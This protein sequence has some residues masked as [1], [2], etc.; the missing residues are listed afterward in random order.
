MSK[1]TFSPQQD[2]SSWETKRLIKYKS[3]LESLPSRQSRSILASISS[4]LNKKISIDIEQRISVLDWYTWL[5]PE[6]KE[7]ISVT[8]EYIQIWNIRIKLFDEPVLMPFHESKDIVPTS[9][10]WSEIIEF[11]SDSD[12]MR[13]Q[14]N[15]NV[16]DFFKKVLKMNT[17]EYATS[18]I[19]TDTYSFETSTIPQCRVLTLWET[20]IS[21]LWSKHRTDFSSVR[22]LIK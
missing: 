21:P 18:T 10:Q 1:N 12:S 22:V 2:F 14:F 17:W 9:K 6:Q 16:L 8:H 13:S 11:L 4:V 5:T 7:S 3:D 15:L 19:Y 20:S